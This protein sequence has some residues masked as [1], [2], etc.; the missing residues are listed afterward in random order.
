MSF[1]KQ[2]AILVGLA[3]LI[4]SGYLG[5]QQRAT[6]AT[7]VRHT[8]GKRSGGP[9]VETAPAAL[10]D[11]ETAVDAVG[12]TRARRSVA[13]T[14]LATGRVTEVGFRAGQQVRQGDVLLRLDS[15]I[16][17]ADLIEAEARL[18][19]AA[20]AIKRNQSLRQ[21]SAVS[22]AAVDKLVVEL[23][24]TQADRDRAAR[25]LRDRTIT[26]PFAGVVGFSGVDLGARVEDGDT[27]AT[28][29]D[30]SLVEIEFALPEGLYARIAPG[31]HIV[32][33]TAAFAGRSFTGTIETIDGRIDPIS[34]AFKARAV[35]AN[36][37]NTLPAGMFMHLAVVLDTRRALTV[38]E[39]AI[40]IDGSHPFVFVV[41]PR[42][43]GLVAERRDVM[44]GQRAFGHVEILEGLETGEDVVVRGVQKARD[45]QPV[46]RAKPGGGNGKGGGDGKP[47]GGNGKGGG[48]G[49][50]GGGNGK[51]GGDGKPAPAQR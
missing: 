41:A 30:L 11:I 16:E 46:R 44:I 38:P 12:T 7:E 25:R 26:A 27:V 36:P 21:S 23:A 45:G 42:G 4:A 43:D 39:E 24:T 48:D 50:P 14:P 3:L 6:V 49:K 32:A 20:S 31:Q 15:D 47:G 35:V 28:L 9:V 19:E 40:V 34:R 18:S 33:F 22:E 2:I 51:G 8:G 29:D 17:R 1:V 10:R 37:D 5:W 13:I